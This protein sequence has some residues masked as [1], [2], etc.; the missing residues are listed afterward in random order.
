MYVYEDMS[1]FVVSR[2]TISLLTMINRKN[3]ICLCIM[4]ITE[5]LKMQ[6]VDTNKASNV[7]NI[8]TDIMVL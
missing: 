1:I 3:V 2:K 6:K 8:L 4:S 7:S 5:L